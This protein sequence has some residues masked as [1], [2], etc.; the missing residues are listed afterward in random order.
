MKTKT[1]TDYPYAAAG[2]VW[3]VPEYKLAQLPDGS[4]VVLKAELDRV[5]RAIANEICGS[6]ERLTVD[7]LDFLCDVTATTYSELAQVLELN[8]ST[9]SRWKRPGSVPSTSTSHGIKRWFWMK[10]F[11]LELAAVQI[12]IAVLENDAG[13]LAY[14]HQQAI[15]EGAA[16]SVLRRVA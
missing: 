7:E 8:K 11:G 6:S 15:A 3:I 2:R 4:L 5:H 13:V 9:L 14:L 12:P 10:L 1:E 16:E